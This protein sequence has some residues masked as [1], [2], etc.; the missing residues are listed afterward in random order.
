MSDGTR[1]LFSDDV[2]AVTQHDRLTL[3]VLAK[4]ITVTHLEQLSKFSAENFERWGRD[5]ATFTVGEGPSIT[6]VSKETRQ[7]AGK[8]LRQYKANTSATVLEGGG[9]KAVAGRAIITGMM[10][11]AGGG[12]SHKIFSDLQKAVDWMAPR[13]PSSGGGEGV[14]PD[15]LYHLIERTRA[16]VKRAR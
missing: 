16:A 2:I 11:I 3:W 5:R 12:N 6:E 13:V 15:E 7:A 1:L 9:F 14:D 8:M 10:M 4:P